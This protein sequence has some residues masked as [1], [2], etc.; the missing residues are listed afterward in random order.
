MQA[1]DSTSENS[2]DDQE[3]KIVETYNEETSE[4]FNDEQEDKIVE[5]YNAEKTNEGGNVINESQAML[6]PSCRL[7][8]NVKPN[9]A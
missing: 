9:V 7:K 1:M 5:T 8:R 3:D 6:H 4:N 2:N